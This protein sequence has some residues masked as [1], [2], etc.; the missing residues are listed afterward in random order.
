MLGW[1]ESEL[2]DSYTE[3]GSMDNGIE[4]GFKEKGEEK[5]WGGEI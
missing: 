5:G 3:R 2:F 1:Y 4:E